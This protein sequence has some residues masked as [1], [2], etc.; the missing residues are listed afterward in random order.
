MHPESETCSKSFIEI[1]EGN[2]NWSMADQFGFWIA[3]II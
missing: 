2:S 1:E 3:I